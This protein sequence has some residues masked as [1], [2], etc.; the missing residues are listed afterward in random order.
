MTSALN[1]MLIPGQ[2]LNGWTGEGQTALIMAPL[3]DADTVARLIQ[4]GASPNEPDDTGF[5]A[6]HLLDGITT[7]QSRF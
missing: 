7:L 4:L 3:K 6:L 1:A 5:N 2:D